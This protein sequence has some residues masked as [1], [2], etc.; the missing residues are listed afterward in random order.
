MCFSTFTESMWIEY[1][2][3]ITKE[4]EKGEAQCQSAGLKPTIHYATFFAATICSNRLQQLVVAC[5][6]RVSAFTLQTIPATC[7]RNFFSVKAIILT[8]MCDILHQATSK[9]H[10]FFKPNINDAVILIR[11][12]QE[13]IFSQLNTIFNYPNRPFPELVSSLKRLLQRKVT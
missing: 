9:S 10:I 3:N 13:K 8:S 4:H 12:T 1:F 6:K 11:A 5:A 2:E 7:K